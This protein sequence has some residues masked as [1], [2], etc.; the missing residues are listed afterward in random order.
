MSYDVVTEPVPPG[1]KVCLVD[2]LSAPVSEAAQYDAIVVR[3]ATFLTWMAGARGS[4]WV[5]HASKWRCTV[6]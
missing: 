1:Q 3:V 6:I 5:Y 4:I 2:S